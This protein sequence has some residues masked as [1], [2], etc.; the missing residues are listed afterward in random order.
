M[1]ITNYFFPFQADTNLL[2]LQDSITY[3]QLDAE[4]A[5]GNTLIW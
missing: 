2:N 5:Q 3:S 4:C 1:W